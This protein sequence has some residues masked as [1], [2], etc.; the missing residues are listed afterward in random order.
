MKVHREVPVWKKTQ[1]AYNGHTPSRT[2]AYILLMLGI[3]NQL[4]EYV[5]AFVDREFLP[6]LVNIPSYIKGTAFLKI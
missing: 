2:N 3:S 4:I 6:V 1:K 5:F